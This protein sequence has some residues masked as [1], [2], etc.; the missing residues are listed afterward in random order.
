[1]RHEWVSDN[2]NTVEDFL[3]P[4]KR[5][6]VKCGAKQALEVQ[7]AWMR[8]VGRHWRPKVGRCKGVKP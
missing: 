7:T 3:G 5:R 2:K 6:C 4:R 1:M 8:I